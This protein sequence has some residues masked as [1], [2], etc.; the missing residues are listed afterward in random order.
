M[1]RQL[2]IAQV[3]FIAVVSMA[4][5][6]YEDGQPHNISSSV[7]DFI[8]IDP[9]S[10]AA[11][12]QTTVNW[13]D[14]ASTEFYVDASQDARVNVYGGQINHRLG[15]N[16]RAIGNVYGGYIETLNNDATAYI[17]N[18]IFERLFASGS[19]SITEI[20]NGT[21]YGATEFSEHAM[22]IIYGGNFY[23]NLSQYYSGFFWVNRAAVDIYGGQFHEEVRLQRGSTVTFYGS[24][25]T[26]DGQ[27]IDYGMIGT[28]TGAGHLYYNEPFQRLEGQ[29]ASGEWIDVNLRICYDTDQVILAV[30]EPTT[31]S[32]LAIGGLFLRRK[33]VKT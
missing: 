13:L 6:R 25:F 7:N 19:N 2:I 14:G 32:L 4:E 21:F 24:N 20:H 10:Y 8:R 26:L 33:K 12:R 29:L 31:L 18:G 16:E 1:K 22:G 17:Q 11:G 3:L 28:I 30:P 27:P 23:N 9:Y 15:I 5:I